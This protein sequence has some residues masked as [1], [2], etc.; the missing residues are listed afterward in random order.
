MTQVWIVRYDQGLYVFSNLD[1][2]EWSVKM[3]YENCDIEREVDSDQAV[4]FVVMNDKHLQDRVFANVFDVHE[5]A[6][7]IHRDE[8]PVVR[9]KVVRQEF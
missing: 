2:V 1:A 4:S 6:T 9:K 5:E 3:M 8:G 7:I